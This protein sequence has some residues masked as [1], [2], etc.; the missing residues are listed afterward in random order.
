M[1]V[2]RLIGGGRV[3]R[4]VQHRLLYPLKH[5]GRRR[6][7]G[8]K[9]K[10]RRAETPHRRRPELTGREAIL[11]TLRLRDGLPRLRRACALEVL[12]LCFELGQKEDFRIIEY[13]VQDDHLHLITEAD[14]KGALSSGMG[15]LV[16]RMAKRLNKLWQRNGKVWFGRFHSEVK[17]TPSMVRNA[18]AYVL[19]NGVKHERVSRGELDPCSSGRSFWYGTP[20]SAVVGAK[21]W[22]VAVG[23]RRAGPISAHS[24]PHFKR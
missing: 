18:L 5:G 22:L 24:P 7:S 8:R 4:Y 21:T 17:H 16:I 15:G 11:V 2:A 12:E 1:S 20:N 13:S 19:H 10:G 6:G 9:P 23:W 14:S 3:L